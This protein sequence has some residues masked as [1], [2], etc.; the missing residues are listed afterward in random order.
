[1]EQG[2]CPIATL[3]SLYSLAVAFQR[4]MLL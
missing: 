1:V 3:Y 4:L 2:N